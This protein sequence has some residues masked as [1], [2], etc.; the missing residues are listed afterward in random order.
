MAN[1]TRPGPGRSC[2]EAG[3]PAQF[4]VE[5]PG[6]TELRVALPV[7]ERLN[8]ASLAWLMP[9]VRA[10]AF[11]QFFQALPQPNHLQLGF[12]LFWS[13][14]GQSVFTDLRDSDSAAA[15]ARARTI[16]KPNEQQQMEAILRLAAHGRPWGLQIT[17]DASGRRRVKLYWFASRAYWAAELVEK[18]S[19]G[20]WKDVVEILGYLLK[21]PGESGRWM[22]SL[23]LDGER[24]KNHVWV[25]NSAWSLVPED[26]DKQ[27]SVAR[28]IRT[29][30]GTVDYA[31]ALWSF[32]RGTADEGWKVGRTCEVGL[33]AGGPEVRLYFTPQPALEQPRE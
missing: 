25:G 22:L 31:E 28:L 26:H 14:D 3:S 23:P 24:E 21:R 5:A 19:P 2:V 9:E 4:M 13:A 15:I 11:A 10:Q 27:R 32:C 17:L 12:W 6:G 1:A 33:K 16:L 29:L 18:F 7:G 8:A 30:G 20:R